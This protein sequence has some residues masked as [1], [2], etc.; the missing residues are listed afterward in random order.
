MI[1]SPS[2]EQLVTLLET[3]ASPC[4]SMYVPMEPHGA[5]IRKN[6]IRFKNAISNAEEQLETHG[7]RPR[8]REALLAPLQGLHD[9]R[10]FWQHQERG[11]AVFRTPDALDTYRTAFA[12]PELVVV[13]KRF[14]LK[15]LLR[16]ISADERFYLLTLSLND[17][18][19]YEASRTELHRIHLE[20]TPTSIAEALRYDVPEK[21]LQYHSKT[22]PPEQQPPQSGQRPAIFHGHGAAADDLEHKKNIQR[23]FRQVDH[24]VERAIA[25]QE[26]PLIVAG[27]DYELSIYRE[28]NTYPHL[29]H[30]SLIGNMENTRE[31]ELHDRAWQH[32]RP[33]FD[34]ARQE[35]VERYHELTE[36]DRLLTDL[37]PIVP[38]AK[39]GRIDALFVPQEQRW[40]QFDPE[41][42]AV[43]LHDT[44]QPGDVD[45]LDTAA[46]WTVRNGG[47][48]YVENPDET[49]LETLPAA[50]LRY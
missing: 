5:E 16:L 42:L 43:E 8:E 19:F 10:P 14:H 50:I 24:G 33:L 28:A 36:T 32:V 15:P 6:P 9:E 34:R 2:S 47:T 41:T 27:V 46:V 1:E 38:A 40:G 31:D 7:V 25:G 12:L 49:A 23:F 48:V 44:R 30:E 17:V 18:R 20:D 3:T 4:I 39:V 35:W 11:L 22:P 26:A 37:R 13:A 21:S 29:V 45:L